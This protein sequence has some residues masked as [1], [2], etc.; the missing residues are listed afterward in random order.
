MK[1]V[2]EI[3]GL[4]DWPTEHDHSEI[5]QTMPNLLRCIIHI[6]SYQGFYFHSFNLAGRE[7]KEPSEIRKARRET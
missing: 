3:V 5:F 6:V 7:W 1:V 4:A 2:E